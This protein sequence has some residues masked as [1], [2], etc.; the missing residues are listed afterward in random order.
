MT[1]K[2][3]PT[4]TEEQIAQAYK[5][6]DDLTKAETVVTKSPVTRDANLRSKFKKAGGEINQRQQ[7]DHIVDLQLGGTNAM[8]NLQALDA[9]VNASFGVQIENQIKN[10]P[11]NTRVNNV[12]IKSIVKE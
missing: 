2:L 10:L 11:D 3:K 5:K 1:I 9:S 8:T 12:Y 6:A 4:W 7:V